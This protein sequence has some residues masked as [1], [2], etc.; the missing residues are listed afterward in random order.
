M[1]RVR[2]VVIAIALATSGAMPAAAQLVCPKDQPAVTLELKQIEPTIDRSMARAELTAMSGATSE[3]TH[4]LG[5]YG[6]TWTIRSQS[7]LQYMKEQGNRRPRGCVWLSSLKLVVAI[8]PRQIRIA[9]ELR[10]D[11]CRYRSVLE[12]ERRHQAVDDDVL[13]RRL[14]WLR[15]HLAG[16]LKGM[17][18]DKP[19]PV[20]ELEALGGKMVENATKTVTTAWQ[21]LVDER[22]RLQREVDTPQEYERVRQQC[23][24]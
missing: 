19:R 6:A 12:H 3:N 23:R 16:A 10:P 13:A 5:M 11:S 20:G 14:P 22:D 18:T 15:D 1:T 2:T 21:Q 17:R 9:R 7:Q 8:D 4:T 24:D